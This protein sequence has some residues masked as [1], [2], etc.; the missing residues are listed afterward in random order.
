MPFMTMAFLPRPPGQRV[1]LVAHV[2]GEAQALLLV[3]QAGVDRQVRADLPRVAQVGRPVQGLALDA[4]ALT[5][6]ADVAARHVLA[7]LAAVLAAGVELRVG[8]GLRRDL[9]EAVREDRRAVV[10]EVHAAGVGARLVG[11]VVL[12]VDAG[13]DLVVAEQLLAA[14][15]REL[16]R[17]AILGVVEDAAEA[18]DAVADVGDVRAVGDVRVGIE[19]RLARGR[20]RRV[21]TAGAGQLALGEVAVEVDDVAPGAQGAAAQHLER[22]VAGAGGVGVTR[23]W[24]RCQPST[25]STSVFESL[26]FEVHLRPASRPSAVR[27]S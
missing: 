13:L 22:D 25:A 19:A 11:E 18:T 14:G 26:N 12:D 9:D 21:E 4:R 16:G 23:R 8:G 6:L 20:R 24:S 17:V 15:H 3:A 7:V 10:L 1:G 2:L 5:G 27:L